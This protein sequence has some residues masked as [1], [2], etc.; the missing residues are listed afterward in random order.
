MNYPATLYK[1]E[2][3]PEGYAFI[4]V[5]TKD[6]LQEYTEF[7]LKNGYVDDDVWTEKPTAI[8]RFINKEK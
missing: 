8:D 2:T 5:L 4:P 3:T 7:L 1:E 6:I